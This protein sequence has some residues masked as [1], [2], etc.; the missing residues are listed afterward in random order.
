MP[1]TKATASSIAPAAKGDLVVG[2]ATNDASVLAV[3]TNN[4]VLTADSTT[5]TGLKWAAPAGGGKVLQV[6]QTTYST[7]ASSTSTSYSDTGLTLNITPSSASSKVLALVNF[8]TGFDRAAASGAV[9]IRLMRSSTSILELGGGTHKQ[10]FKLELSN[11][12]FVNPL[13]IFSFN[14]LDSPSTTSATTYKVQFGCGQQPGG[15]TVTAYAQ[16]DSNISVLT[17]MEIGA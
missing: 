12:A 4:H 1:I 15:A 8:A 9:R 16:K 14:Y 11:E 7:E 5:A 13:D 17:L 3:G 10:A 6:V 2:S